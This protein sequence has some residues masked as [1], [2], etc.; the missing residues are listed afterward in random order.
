MRQIEELEPIERRVPV[1]SEI[2]S[3]STSVTLEVHL[4]CPCGGIMNPP[5][6]L[7]RTYK[8]TK[9]GSKFRVS[10]EKYPREEV[11]VTKMEEWG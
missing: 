2:L 8:C 9:C 7:R 11:K 6:W 3:G 5:S 4:D 1:H 10:G